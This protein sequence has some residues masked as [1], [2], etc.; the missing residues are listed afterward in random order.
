MM[1]VDKFMQKKVLNKQKSK[2]LEAI[3][4]YYRH[5]ESHISNPTQTTIKVISFELCATVLVW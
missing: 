3:D 1:T 4:Y 2:Q 5:L